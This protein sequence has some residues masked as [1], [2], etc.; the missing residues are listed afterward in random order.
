M[1]AP[2]EESA[3]ELDCD[4]AP[5]FYEA[6]TEG[7]AFFWRSRKLRL[8]LAVLAEDLSRHHPLEK[9]L[10]DQRT[11]RINIQHRLVYQVLADQQSVKVLRLWTHYD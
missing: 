9:L 10:G 4:V 8:F 7:K 3:T 2:L 5:I 6:G 1:D 11:R